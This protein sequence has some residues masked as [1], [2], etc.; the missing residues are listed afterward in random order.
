MFWVDL[1]NPKKK[2]ALLIVESDIAYIEIPGLPKYNAYI[3]HIAITDTLDESFS[4]FE[5]YS[6]QARATSFKRHIQ[7]ELYTA[8]R[9][10][11]G[12]FDQI[13]I[14]ENVRKEVL[15]NYTSDEINK[16]KTIDGYKCELIKKGEIFGFVILRE[17]LFELEEWSHATFL[18][19]FAMTCSCKFKNG[20]MKYYKKIVELLNE[21]ISTEEDFIM[22]QREA[23]TE[24]YNPD[25]S[26]IVFEYIS[27][28]SV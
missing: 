8:Y 10:Y 9:S 21:R 2:Y 14:G 16:I 15:L 24:F 26:N 5:Q 4:V 11:S 27:S 25:I 18:L 23:L 6:E 12:R 28:F 1:F 22:E 3:K 7:E 13:Y 19:D 20:G 17:D